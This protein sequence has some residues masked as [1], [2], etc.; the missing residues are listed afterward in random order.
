LNPSS[1][2]ETL[3][4][5][6]ATD[7]IYKHLKQSSKAAHLID[8][9]NHDLHPLSVH[10]NILFRTLNNWDEIQYRTS[11][12]TQA[13]LDASNRLASESLIAI[14]LSWQDSKPLKT[15]TIAVTMYLPATLLAV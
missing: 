8:A 5:L 7:S 12:A 11:E 2:Q 10:V 4:L 9:G 1:Q 15:L 13:S 3:I 6:Q 14:E